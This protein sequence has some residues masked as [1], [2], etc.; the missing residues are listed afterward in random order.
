MIMRKVERKIKPFECINIKL[1]AYFNKIA[2]LLNLE[3]RD[4][5]ILPINYFYL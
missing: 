1:L 5:F 3:D 4:I 2:Y